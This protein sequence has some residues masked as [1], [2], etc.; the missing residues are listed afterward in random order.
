MSLET[1]RLS[2]LYGSQ[3]KTI[4]KNGL[5]LVY[6]KLQRNF[7]PTKYFEN[8]QFKERSTLKTWKAEVSLNIKKLNS[9]RYPGDMRV[10]FFNGPPNKAV[11]MPNPFME[12][13]RRLVSNSYNK[14]LSVSTS[15]KYVKFMV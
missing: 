11:M 13:E 1:V 5:V 9:T 4:F 14:H 10:A 3:K 2:F 15:Q 8:I 7:W 6:M 12:Q